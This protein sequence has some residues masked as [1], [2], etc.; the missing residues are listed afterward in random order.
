MQKIIITLPFL[1]VASL[2]FLVADY[3]SLW[4]KEPAS[5][6]EIALVRFKATDSETGL[7]VNGYHVRCWGYGNNDI[8]TPA[9][10]IIERPG[11]RTARI[12]VKRNYEKGFLFSHDRGLD[13]QENV[14]FNLWVIHGDYQTLKLITD[15]SDLI[16]HGENRKNLSLTKR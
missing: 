3:Y 12:A 14:S 16:K 6:L 13:L 8:C 7:P 5:Q 15:Y 11:E 9:E 10:N 1:I 2:V 4:K